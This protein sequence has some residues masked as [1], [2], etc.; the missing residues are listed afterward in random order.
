MKR[1][2]MLAGTGMLLTGSGI[3]GTSAAFGDSVTATASDLRVISAEKLEVRAGPAFNDD[4]SVRSGYTDRYVAYEDT[5]ESM[6]F[7]NNGG[8]NKITTDDSPVATVNAREDN[9]NNE[10]SLETAI[11]LGDDGVIFEDIL[12]I[13][14]IGTVDKRV[15]ISYDRDQGQYGD[16]VNVGGNVGNELTTLDVQSVYRFIADTERISPNQNL[17]GE[18][19][20]DPATF[21]QIESGQTLPIDLEIDLTTWD[22]GIVNGDPK[23]HI[24]QEAQLGDPFSGSID[25]V[26]LLDSITV[27][28]EPE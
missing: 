6:F 20:D 9:V 18:E 8:L 1:R 15:G 13:A 25:T 3:I 24:R 21:V 12:E 19:I 4:G 10:L 23:E 14:N 16:D 7:D 5:A 27:G 2:A 26:D 17:V 22:I 11:S 28:T